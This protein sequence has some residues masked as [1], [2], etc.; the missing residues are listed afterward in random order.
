[1][2]P[3]LAKEMYWY[4]GFSLVGDLRSDELRGD[5]EAFGININHYGGEVK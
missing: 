4:D 1:M 3:V 2:V 5:I